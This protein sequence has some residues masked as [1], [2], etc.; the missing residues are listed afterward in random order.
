M[1]SVKYGA[2][3]TAGTTRDGLTRLSV[4]RPR[5]LEAE[6]Y[7]AGS[8]ADGAWPYLSIE[9]CIS[10]LTDNA[11]ETSRESLQRKTRRSASVN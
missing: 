11:I 2:Y 9:K 7:W 1:G 3:S 5:A 8:L 6:G 4:Q 10:F